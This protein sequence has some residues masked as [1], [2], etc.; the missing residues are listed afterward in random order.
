MSTPEKKR[1]SPTLSAK[2]AK[3]YDNCGCVSQFARRRRVPPCTRISNPLEMR[4]S[5]LV[6]KDQ[7]NGKKKGY[8]LP[9]HG[10]EE[11]KKKFR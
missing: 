7:K 5:I 4:N 8:D 3:T 9:Q 1:R 2:R 10:R 11:K 6:S